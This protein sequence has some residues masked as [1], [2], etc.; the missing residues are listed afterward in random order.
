MKPESIESD[1]ETS[2]TQEQAAPESESA[3]PT[4]RPKRWPLLLLAVFLAAIFIAINYPYKRQE[5]VAKTVARTGVEVDF[6]SRKIAMPSMGGWPFRYLILFPDQTRFSLLALTYNVM[7][8]ISVSALVLFLFARRRK[9]GGKVLRISISDLLLFTLVLAVPFGYWQY[10]ESRQKKFDA[11]VNELQRSGAGLRVSAAVPKFAAMFI[12][13]SLQEKLR[14]VRVLRI[15]APTDSIV[16]QIDQ[17]NELAVLRLGGGDYDLSLLKNLPS[18][19][20]IE[21]LRIAGRELD[22]ATFAAIR[23]CKRLH[24]LNLMRTN[25]TAKAV[26]KLDQMP[27]LRR[28]CLMRTDVDLAELVDPPW[29][30]SVREL[31]LSHGLPGNEVSCRIGG[32]K[33]LEFL[34]FGDME[35][36]V[37]RSVMTVELFDLPQLKTLELEIFQ[38]YDLSLEN[39]PLLESVDRRASS[40]MSRV[41]LGGSVATQPYLSRLRCVDLPELSS[42]TLYILGLKELTLQSVPKLQTIFP[43]IYEEAPRGAVYHKTVPLESTKTL[44]EGIGNSNMPRVYLHSIPLTGVDLSPLVKNTNIQILNLTNTNISFAQLQQLKGMP[45]LRILLLKDNPIS[46]KTINWI[47]ANFDGLEELSFSGEALNAGDHFGQQTLEIV[48]QPKLKSL[49]MGDGFSTARLNKVRI[50]GSPNL[51]LDLE[52]YYPNEIELVDAKSLTG[53]AV[54]DI[55]PS[56]AKLGVLPNLT[57]F[58]VGGPTVTDKTLDCLKG[59]TKLQ[60]LTLAYPKVSREALAKLELPNQISSLFLPGAALDDEVVAQWP[61]FPLLAEIDFSDTKITIESIKKLAAKSSL[62]KVIA[63]RTDVLPTEL[64]FLENE[65]LAVLSLEDIGIDAASLDKILTNPLVSLTELNLSGTTVSPEVLDVILNKGN[66]LRYLQLRNCKLD[67]RKLLQIA[68]FNRNLLFDL[69]GSSVSPQIYSGLGNANRL[70][71]PQE[72]VYRWKLVQGRGRETSEIASVIH[73]SRFKNIQPFPLGPGTAA[74]N[75]SGGSGF[76]SW[77][78]SLFSGAGQKDAPDKESDQITEQPKVEAPQ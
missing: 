20:H 34:R 19:P 44:I 29:K 30:D 40:L 46:T 61:A 38:K 47:F 32:W 71:D 11:M 54:H 6:Y 24:T 14:Q 62:T 35:S 77:I 57:F 28:V 70:A 22:A 59:N 36:Q 23:D 33:S 4:K 1:Q 64:G 13:I 60:K 76:G 55:L 37:N 50:V 31:R 27:S 49:D 74:P 17:F 8:A 58:A 5:T 42:V 15:E 3:N 21:E 69:D 78:G 12:P 56:T 45:R 7:I 68:Q 65:S 39:I 53:F 52:L 51:S 66:T 63:D 9:D 48:D 43:V 16:K 25:V 41:P 2:S 75:S 72:W 18:N 26:S 10:L 67:D 73:T